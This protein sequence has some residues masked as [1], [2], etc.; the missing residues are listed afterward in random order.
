MSDPSSEGKT[1]TD[2]G[3]TADE[4][5]ADR[6]LGRELTGLIQSRDKGP[7]L[8]PADM[9]GLLEGGGR[10]PV[11]VKEKMMDHIA[12]CDACYHTFM[13]GTRLQRE[14][15]KPRA[16]PYRSLA[17]AASALIVAVFLILVVQT[18][19]VPDGSDAGSPPAPVLEE[20]ARPAAEKIEMEAEAKFHDAK[21]EQEYA[22]DEENAP[23]G[24][25]TEKPAREKRNL[26]A[27]RSRTE[28]EAKDVAAG[29]DRRLSFKSTERAS[30][31]EAG[32]K[33]VGEIAA[34]AGKKKRAPQRKDKDRLA[35]APAGRQPAK[36]AEKETAVMEDSVIGK[37]APA[38]LQY[39]SRDRPK[40]DGE[41]QL[42]SEIIERHANGM[43]KVERR[44][45]VEEGKRRLVEVWEY[46][47][48]GRPLTVL[49]V[50]K[51]IQF[52]LEYHP[53]GQVKRERVYQQ[54]QAH[55]LWQSWDRKGNLVK[56]KLYRQ[57]RL[58]KGK[59][60]EENN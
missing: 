58:V 6:H 15:P 10:I 25:V 42:A 3:K 27:M 4:A 7:C 26:P 12:A 24:T 23:V 11:A 55:G 22:A 37:Q 32:E 49:E 14:G 34:P 9:A 21:A 20:T 46:D 2:K 41:K 1:M 33:R 16:I 35:A 47:A 43:K 53:D 50:E 60:Q 52:V 13:L 48:M 18:D 54:G 40:G 17:L 45:A 29:I 57:G 5:A 19:S 59:K 51:E 30:E 56:Q 36:A 44:Y 31:P 28:G 39:Q 8:S 38:L